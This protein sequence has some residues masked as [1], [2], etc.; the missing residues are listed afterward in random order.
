L[1]GSG[2][3]HRIGIGGWLGHFVGEVIAPIGRLGIPHR[4]IQP[5]RLE[6]W[7]LRLAFRIDHH[8]LD[9]RDLGGQFVWRRKRI[10]VRHEDWLT[11]LDRFCKL[12]EIAA[13][14]G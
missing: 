7:P 9:H 13:C 10:F 2:L 4:G 11:L 5:C 6:V 12:R 8:I 14:P 1:N 3:H